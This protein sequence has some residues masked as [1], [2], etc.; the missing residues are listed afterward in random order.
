M[1]IGEVAK[2]GQSCPPS[3][4]APWEPPKRQ[5]CAHG[6][7]G[8]QVPRKSQQGVAGLGPRVERVTYALS[9]REPSQVRTFG[10]PRLS[11]A[12]PT[13]PLDPDL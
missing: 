8:F 7:W 4:E 6:M 5:K 3:K 13:L 10:P 12:Q 2:G 1:D 9:R 11:P